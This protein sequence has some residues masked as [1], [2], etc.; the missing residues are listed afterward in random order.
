[1][2]ELKTIRMLSP[3]MGED[4]CRHAINAA[5]DLDVSGF[6]VVFDATLLQLASQAVG[7]GVSRLNVVLAMAKAQTVLNM[8]RSTSRQ[9]GRL[10]EMNLQ[11]GAFAGQ[12]RTTLWGGVAIFADKKCTEFVGAIA[13]SGGNQEQ[14]EHIC[15]AAVALCAN[16]FVDVGHEGA[17]S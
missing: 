10:Q 9:R 12:I 6:V 1:M 2:A 17:L 13:F 15:T 7:D 5:E 11:P 16:V 3:R 14:D 8:H 4:L